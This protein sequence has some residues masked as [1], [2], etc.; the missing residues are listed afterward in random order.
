MCLVEPTRMLKV[1]RQCPWVGSPKPLGGETP[2]TLSVEAHCS[3]T[4][5]GVA[6]FYSQTFRF[7]T[8]L[9]PMFIPL[10]YHLN[11]YYLYTL[12]ATGFLSIYSSAVIFPRL[13]FSAFINFIS[14]T[15]SIV[16]H[17]YVLP[18]SPFV[19]FILRF[20]RFISFSVAF[21]LSQSSP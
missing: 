11:R 8:D 14:R 13:I 12:L 17:K 21:R 5:R 10:F 19:I 6:D 18:F 3:S 15:N 16:F 4:D 20:N 9:F 2:T 1:F 7:C